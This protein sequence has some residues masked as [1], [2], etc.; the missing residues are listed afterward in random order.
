MYPRGSEDRVVDSW[1]VYY[2]EFDHFVGASYIDWEF[3]GTF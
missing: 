1:L 3:D 2:R